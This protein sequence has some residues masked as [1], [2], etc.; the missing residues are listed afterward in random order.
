M[1][2]AS[3][4]L[5][6]YFHFGQQA[7]E[8]RSL[9]IQM[10][11]LAGQH[12]SQQSAH[13]LAQLGVPARLRRLALQRCK[14]LF[15][16]HINVVDPRKIDLRGFQLRF[17]QPPFGFVHSDPG[18]FL[19]DRPP[20]HRPRVEDL[21]DSALLDDRVAIRSQPDAHENL[22]DVAKPRHPAVDE[23]FALAGAI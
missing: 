11:G 8:P 3:L 5:L 22:L 16:L 1:D 10:P 12:D 6:G 18:G 14:L 13:L 9:G 2:G 17:R 4:A 15:Y 20:V 23:I 21:A 7:L 19:D